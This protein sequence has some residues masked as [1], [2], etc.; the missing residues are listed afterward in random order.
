MGVV[1]GYSCWSGRLPGGPQAIA[2]VEQ[3]IGHQM[4]PRARDSSPGRRSV[5]RRRATR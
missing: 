3:L 2:A 4:G 1:A 5:G